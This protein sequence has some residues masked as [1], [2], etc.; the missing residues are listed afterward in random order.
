VSGFVSPLSARLAE[1][2]GP[3]VLIVGS[4]VG[5]SLGLA[6]IAT[7]VGSA[8]VWL[9]AVLRIPV[10]ICGLLA[11]QPTTTVL[12]ESVPAHRSGVASSV[13]NT[14]RQ[15]GGALAVAVFGALLAVRGQI[16][17]GVRESLVI[18][19]VVALAAAVANL[20]PAPQP[21]QPSPPPRQP[22]LAS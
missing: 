13:F 21:K 18:A 15:L 7:V 5:M 3:R 6:V 14:S 2:F 8:P 4:M 1:R 19:A 12:L 22:D 17:D 20:L 10:G 9:L 16:L 11:M